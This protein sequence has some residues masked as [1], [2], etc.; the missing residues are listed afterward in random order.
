MEEKRSHLPAAAEEPPVPTSKDVRLVTE[1]TFE[2]WGYRLP[3]GFL[4]GGEL[5]RSFAFRPFRM[6]EEEQLEKLRGGK[7]KRVRM[8]EFVAGVLAYM[9]TRLGPYDFETLSETERRLVVNQMWQQDVLYAYIYLRIDAL[10]SECAFNL[11]CA[12]CGHEWRWV[13]D[14][15]R[16][17]VEIAEDAKSLVFTHHL[18][19][20][21]ETPDGVVKEILIQPARWSAMS[22]IRSKT[23][24]YA[25]IKLA[26]MA[27]AIKNVGDGKHP[28]TREMLETLTKYDSEALTKAI[29]DLTPGPNLMLEVECPECGATF[30][31]ALDWN[32]DFFFTASSLPGQKGN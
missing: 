21:L 17:D 22:Q 30:R 15:G 1:S 20:G 32:Y 5:H 27:S 11:E 26:L 10:G 6:R 2:D 24:N 8:P 13:A 28:I 12:T 29:D 16:T 3:I 7:K 4:Q 14:L 19:D 31:H 23:F 25:E 18:R 9:L